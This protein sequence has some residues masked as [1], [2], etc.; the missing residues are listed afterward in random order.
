MCPNALGARN[1]PATALNPMT[2]TLYIPIA[3]TCANYTYSPR[4]AAETA[5]GGSDIR[6]G[7]ASKPGTDGLY[8]R[9]AAV[10]LT[11]RKV[12]W[13]KRQREPFAS[14]ILSTGG[15]LIFSG[16]RDRMFRALDERTGA[17]LWE[18]RLNASPSSFPV[19][20]SVD[21]QQYVAVVAGGGGPLDASGLANAP[22][23]DNPSEGI[24][25]SV[26]KLPGRAA[27]RPRRR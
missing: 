20:Y 19:T 6:T 10:D 18:T 13:T 21:G 12:I 27:A 3:E 7:R 17:V 5:A 14:A 23:V 8:G 4:S 24:T 16:S 1:W 26:F 15:G 11:T 9:I 22:E 2:H 25:L